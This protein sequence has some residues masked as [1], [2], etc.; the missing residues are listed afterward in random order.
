MKTNLQEVRSN[1]DI[2]HYDDEETDKLCE[3]SSALEVKHVVFPYFAML[4][5][6]I[7]SITFVTES[8]VFTKAFF[9]HSS[10]HN[11]TRPF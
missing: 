9:K 6:L 8:T 4:V 3:I 7:A 2:P 11:L 1:S 5:K 10:I